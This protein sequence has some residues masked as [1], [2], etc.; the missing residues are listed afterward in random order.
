MLKMNF[1]QKKTYTCNMAL[2]CY[3]LALPL[4]QKVENRY[5]LWPLSPTF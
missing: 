2:A 5:D 1:L 3:P 4:F